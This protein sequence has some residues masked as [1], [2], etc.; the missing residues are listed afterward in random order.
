MIEPLINICW[1]KTLAAIKAAADL[2]FK[3]F[4]FI[5]YGML[6]RGFYVV[7]NLHF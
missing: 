3:D 6:V 5:S 1:E 7:F 2:A 4:F